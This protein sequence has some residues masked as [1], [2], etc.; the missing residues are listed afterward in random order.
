MPVSIEDILAN[1]ILQS[2]KSEDKTG[3]FQQLMT[4]HARIDTWKATLNKLSFRVS[5]V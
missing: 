5:S 3:T 4:S 1:I 2:Q